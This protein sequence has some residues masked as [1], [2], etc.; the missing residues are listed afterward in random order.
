M[1]QNLLECEK[2]IIKLHDYG[3]EL[4]EPQDGHTVAELCRLPNDPDKILRA[5]PD[6]S[7]VIAKP[8]G[9]PE[10][11]G[12]GQTTGVWR[13]LA[14]ARAAGETQLRPEVGPAAPGARGDVR[15]GESPDSAARRR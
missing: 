8:S 7:G 2:M 10:G 1:R 12:Q 15:T 4:A 3:A 6:G 14:G 9:G 5:T 11:V 13:E